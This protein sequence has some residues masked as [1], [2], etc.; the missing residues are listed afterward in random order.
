MFK[1]R[2][3][4]RT[5]TT[6]VI[7]GAA[8]DDAEVL[9]RTRML[10]DEKDGAELLAALD[11]LKDRDRAAS[12]RTVRLGSLGMVSYARALDVLRTYRDT[13]VITYPQFL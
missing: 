5:M 9:F 2:R 10:T 6:T 8:L 12:V 1:I 7:N 4:R 3:R 11:R 13:S